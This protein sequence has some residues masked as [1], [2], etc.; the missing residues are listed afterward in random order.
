MS[1]NV[2]DM[3]QGL[4]TPA[5]A[6]SAASALGESEGGI[7]KALG[8]AFPAIL[9]QMANGAGDEGL[10]G[11]I[12]GMVGDKLIGSVLGSGGGILSQAGS[13]LS[14]GSSSPLMSIGSTLL[15]MLFGDKIGGLAGMLGSLAGIKPASARSLLGLAGPMVL[16]VLGNKLGGAL[17]G[18]VLSN[19]L[20]SQKQ[21]LLAAVPAQL[22]GALGALPSLGNAGRAA[23]A[24]TTAAAAS[25]ADAAD[26]ARRRAGAAVPPPPRRASGGGSSI[27]LW[28]LGLVAA[29]VLVWFLSTLKPNE[30]AV[31]RKA[32]PPKAAAPAPAP[33]PKMA[34]AP[35]PAP[36]PPAPA[37]AVEAAK[38]TP[39]PAA[40]VS[41]LSKLA[42][43]G[44]GLARLAL[45]TGKTI[46][47]GENGVESRL[48]RL[49]EDVKTPLD[50]GTWL[51]FDRLTFKTA[52]SELTPES[53]SQVE[54]LAEIMK[55]F[56][57]T[58][59]KIGGYTDNQGDAAKNLA[60]SD[61]RAKSVMKELVSL[62]IGAD[63]LA[64]EG[65]GEQFPVADNA[66]A[67]GRQKNR[68]T[69]L[70]LRQR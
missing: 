52:S 60:L 4:A 21:C 48:I 2:L 66:T 37:P 61:E 6:R 3:L 28:M 29:G 42:P 40:P 68:R 62:G 16:A 34:E 8:A 39:A 13:V 49:I 19:V 27:L 56:A 38:P 70:S 10:M 5:L 65:Y 20:G 1:F 59:V 57:T 11:K 33:A 51:D 46:E 23:A 25:T 12:A 31:V 18:A 64:A 53:R 32:E 45:P 14:A 26:A 22:S 7:A 43:I 55:A 58:Q 47:I 24:A 50:K 54:A 41:I 30:P 67:E 44:N 15:G 63:R 9:A 17:T 35:K 36:A 69:A